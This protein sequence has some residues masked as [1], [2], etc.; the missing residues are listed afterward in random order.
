MLNA[1]IEQTSALSAS[2]EVLICN[3]SL[4]GTLQEYLI[5][6]SEMLF[7]GNVFKI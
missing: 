4:A 1:R 3:L 2:E 5:D 6:T 7:V